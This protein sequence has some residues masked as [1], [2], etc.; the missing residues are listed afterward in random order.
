MLAT[1]TYFA[2]V[3]ALTA[4]GALWFRDR[5]R[6]RRDELRTELLHKL[7]RR[8]TNFASLLDEL[9]RSGAVRVSRVTAVLV[10]LQR[11]GLIDARW[12]HTTEGRP[13]RTYTVASGA[14]ELAGD[15]EP[16]VASKR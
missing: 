6:E 10:E 15:F 5:E 8:P 4:V 1:L 11:D 12:E 2:F 9:R 3:V 13:Y 16:A 14:L 7:R